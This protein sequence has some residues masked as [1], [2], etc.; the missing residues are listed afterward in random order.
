MVD[1]EMI[2]Q[3]NGYSTKSTKLTATSAENSWIL[4]QQTK[5]KTA[6]DNGRLVKVP[7]PANGWRKA[8]P[9][10]RR[11]HGHVPR[12]ASR[13]Q[14]W[15]TVGRTTKA[16]IYLRALAAS[17]DLRPFFQLKE[18]VA[19][20][21]EKSGT[22]TMMSHAKANTMQEA[23]TSGKTQTQQPTY[24]EPKHDARN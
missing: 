17:V 1:I 16:P 13:T 8:T 6:N 21:A 24:D 12:W 5:H 7:L 19:Y 18:R 11:T 4:T 10:T 20:G 2:Q 14:S 23:L 22:T 15:T 9:K 3:I